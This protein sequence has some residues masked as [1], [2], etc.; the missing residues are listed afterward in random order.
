MITGEISFHISAQSNY[1]Y[2]LIL[3]NSVIN[4]LLKSRSLSV[5]KKNHFE[6]KYSVTFVTKVGTITW[7]NIDYYSKIS[8]AK[9]L[10]GQILK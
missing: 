1:S 10:N 9:I 4:G 6:H 5:D 2:R 7:H 3:K 8:R